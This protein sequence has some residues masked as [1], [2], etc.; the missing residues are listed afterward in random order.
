M[1]EIIDY[2]WKCHNPTQLNQQGPD[3]GTQYRSAIYYYSEAQK[4]IAENSKNEL[5]KSI[6]KTIVTEITKA[7]EFFPAEEYH[8]CFIQKKFDNEWFSLCLYYSSLL[9]KE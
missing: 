9:K 5:Q 8:Q 7:K 6:S 1:W 2:F 4:I 3:I